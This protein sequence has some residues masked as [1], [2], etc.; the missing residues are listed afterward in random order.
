MDEIVEEFAYFSIENNDLYCFLD[1]CPMAIEVN[2]VYNVELDYFI[3]DK[4]ILEEV[5][6]DESV[7]I[8]FERI[9]DSTQY[10]ITGRLDGNTFTAGNICFVDDALQLKYSYLDGRL[11]TLT[12]WRL[13][14]SVISESV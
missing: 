4:F 5:N 1:Y 6:T 11:I 3:V 12:V 14:I 13:N 7:I 8:P 2:K 10:K 9:G